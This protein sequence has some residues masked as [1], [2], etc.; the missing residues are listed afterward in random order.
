MMQQRGVPVLPVTD[1]DGK[2]VGLFTME[3]IGEMLMV[4]SA[5]A[6]SRRERV[7][8]SRGPGAAGGGTPRRRIRAWR[9]ASA[10]PGGMRIWKA[11]RSARN[12]R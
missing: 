1:E 8:F 2:L 4:R 12:C 5:I 6:D 3:N 11:I 9:R 7:A 10:D